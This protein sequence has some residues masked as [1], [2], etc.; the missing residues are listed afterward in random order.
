MVSET[1]KLSFSIPFML[2]LQPLLLYRDAHM[3]VI[4]K[5]PGVA[6]H[7]GIGGDKLGNLQ[8]YLDQLQFGLPKKPELAH[9]LDAATSGCLVLGRHPQALKTL[10]RLFQENKVTKTY[11]A[12]VVGKPSVAEGV[13]DF[14]LAKQSP[15]KHRWW[16]K[17]DPNGQRAITHFKVLQSDGDFSLLELCP[18]TGRTHQLRVHCQALGHPILGD[19]IYGN[20]MAKKFQGLFLHARKIEI[21]FNLKKPPVIVEAAI[22]DYMRL[23]LENELKMPV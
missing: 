5:P 9:R 11:L 12:V 19:G 15:H 14:P 2:N 17:V 7:P 8:K 21:P 18:Q 20:D 13:M 6:V 1:T 10:G 4:N 16:M 23:F 22:S 3:L